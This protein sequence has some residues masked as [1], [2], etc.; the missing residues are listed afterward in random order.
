MNSLQGRETARAV[1]SSGTHFLSHSSVV[2]PSTVLSNKF[3]FI[4]NHCYYL[5]QGLTLWP[6]LALMNQPLGDDLSYVP[7]RP[8]SAFLFGVVFMCV[9]LPA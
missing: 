8:V 6:R 9:Y 7:P 5:K 2:F 4:I 1:C 3:L